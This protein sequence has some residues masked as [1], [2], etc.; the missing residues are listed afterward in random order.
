[1]KKFI[2]PA[3]LAAAVTFAFLPSHAQAHGFSI[4][5][6]PGGGYYAPAYSYPSY[7]SPPVYYTPSYYGGASYY[8]NSYSGY[9]YSP[10]Y[11]HEWRE[12]EEHEHHEWHENHG[13]GGYDHHHH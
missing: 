6:N 2:L 4:S 5:I 13:Y 1:L 7:Y 12:H 11:N 8:P 9:G 3:L 10:Y